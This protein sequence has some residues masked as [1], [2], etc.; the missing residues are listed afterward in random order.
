MRTYSPKE[1][2]A[3]YYGYEITGFAEDEMIVC[4]HNADQSEIVVGNDGQATRT[5]NP[6]ASGT[7]TITLKQS[8][9]TNDILSGL[10][11]KD[12]LDGSVVGPLMIRDNRGTSLSVGTDSVIAKTPAQNFGRTAGNRVWVFKC[13]QLLNFAGGNNES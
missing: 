5:I 3:T 2:S 10:A 8:S 12:R 7:I 1:V 9:P 6:D 13:G 11:V 4:E